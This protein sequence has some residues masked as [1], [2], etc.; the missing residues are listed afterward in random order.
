MSKHVEAEGGELLIES[1][2][3][4][5]AII[6]K[7]MA[8]WVKEHIKSGNHAV[9]DDY[10]KRLQE[11]KPNKKAQEGMKI[12]PPARPVMAVDATRTLTVKPAFGKPKSVTES[13]EILPI[14]PFGMVKLMAKEKKKK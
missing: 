2:N 13:F 8:A 10:V 9:V 6:P 3:G 4:Y 7:N 14:G 11:M 5:S 1:S 12:K